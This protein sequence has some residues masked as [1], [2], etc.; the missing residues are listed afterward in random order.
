MDL[1]NQGHAQQQQQVEG[2]LRGMDST[3]LVRTGALAHTTAAA[4]DAAA[5]QD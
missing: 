5:G 2:Q 4:T 1:L 3:A